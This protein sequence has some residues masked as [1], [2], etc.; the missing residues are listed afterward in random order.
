MGINVQNNYAVKHPYL[1][2]YLFYF[3]LILV[4][5]RKKQIA[6]VLE[7]WVV[8]L[9]KAVTVTVIVTSRQVLDH[10][11]VGVEAIS[12]ERGHHLMRERYNKHFALNYMQNVANQTVRGYL[13]HIESI[14]WLILMTRYRSLPTSVRPPSVVRLVVIFRKLSKID[15]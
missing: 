7:C 11:M 10:V 1:L 12:Q 9:W 5:N 6:T 15:P 4:L 8:M 3:T 13:F 2:T 14:L